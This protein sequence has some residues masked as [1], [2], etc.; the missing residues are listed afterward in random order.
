MRTPICTTCLMVF[1][2]IAAGDDGQRGPALGVEL[3]ADGLVAPLDL[4][5]A[6][7]ESGRRFIVDQTGLV[8][9]LTPEGE[10]LPTPFLDIQDR[11][12]LQSAFDERGLLSL[13]FHPDFS[14]N[15]RLYVHYSAEREGPNICVDENGQIPPDPAGCPFQYTRRVSEF[16]VSP[17]QPNE[18]D[19]ATER[20]LFKIEW[21]GRKH[22]GGGLAF[23]PD[24][25]LYVGLGDGGWI[26]GPD[27]SGSPFEVDPDLL[28]GDETAQDLTQLYGKI[29]RIDVNRDDFPNDPDRN[30]GIPPMNPFVGMSA[31]P[32]E[33]FAWGFRNPFRMSFD[34]GGD[35]ALYV[36]A[37]ADTFFEAIYKI[38][39]PGNY[40]WA[41]KEG[42]HCIVR[43]SALAPPETIL[44]SINQEC[45]VG[46][47]ISFCN[48]GRCDCSDFGP[49]G[50]P[51]QDPVVEYLNF[52]VERP[53]SQFP[54]EG[55]GRASLGGHIYRG[56][57]I[58]WLRGQLVAGDFAINTFDGQILVAKPKNN[59]LW[60]LR[61][62]F[63][64]DANDPAQA[65]FMKSVGI[66]A[67]GELYAITGNFTPTGLQGR[68]WKIVNGQGRTAPPGQR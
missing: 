27:G 18:V 6:P 42:T 20:I 37:T 9:I 65:G 57:A 35:R 23:G 66:D 12:V 4:T 48:N 47:Q 33:I 43:S 60:Q 44:C 36:S 30:Y 17:A 5:F 53:G 61:R 50:E 62:A 22:N 11:V 56:A 32:D 58:P 68:V 64:F 1:V 67:D 45:P 49:L 24:G 28:F 13:V 10:I 29:L 51:I 40:G 63:V 55:F 8:L 31:L 39:G 25:L 52:S 46:P 21:P 59:K 34:R 2:A 19:P 26:H 16:T 14:Q 54:G 38:D 41:A 3:V 7:D 15:G